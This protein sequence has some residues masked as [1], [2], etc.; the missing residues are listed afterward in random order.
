MPAHRK[1]GLTPLSGPHAAPSVA[2][3][4]PWA[5]LRG[6]VDAPHRRRPR[7]LSENRKSDLNDST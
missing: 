5:A 2:F 3:P 1:R 6:L 7:A 4:L